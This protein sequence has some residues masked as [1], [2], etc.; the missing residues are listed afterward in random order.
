MKVLFISSG[1]TEFR[2]IPFV[3]SQEQSLIDSGVKVDHFLISE[4]GLGGYLRS[5]SKLKDHLKKNT[6]ELIHAHYTFCG[7][8]AVLS[9]CRI[10]VVVSYMGS[11]VYGTVDKNGKRIPGSYFEIIT[12]ILL[13]PFVRR[14]IVK[15]KN[16]EQYVYLKKKSAVI[17][18]GVDFENFKPRDKITARKKLG[19]SLDH[20]LICFLGNPKNLRKNIRLLRDSVEI[21]NNFNIKLI[22][23]YPVSSDLIPYY[24]N[25]CDVLVLCS[26]LEGSPNVVK[27]AM[28]S[29]CPIVATDVGD[30][31]EI[32][33]NTE[34][35]YISSFDPNDM[36]EKIT[37]AL[38]LNAPTTGRDD[39]GHL[40]IK[41]I[42]ERI[43][44]VYQSCTS[45]DKK[46]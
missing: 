41:K 2:V 1:A 24:I 29:N 16:L 43:I 7:W 22:C 11:D 30:A 40:E 36:A 20:Q 27:E 18:N 5:I 45:N 8:V 12:G 6:Y 3:K 28:A 9:F 35:C 10:P 15:S 19:L 17:P 31:K 33:G 26:F 25:S 42:A 37:A 39:V 13:Q 34:G 4:G 21:I 32:I 38:K 14:I 44:E 46:Q 23:P